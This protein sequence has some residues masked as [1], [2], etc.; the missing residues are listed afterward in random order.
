MADSNLQQTVSRAFKGI[1][2]F[3]EDATFIV[4]GKN[5]YNTAT[6]KVENGDSESYDI[7]GL[8]DTVK[9]AQENR[10]DVTFTF[11]TADLKNASGTVLDLSLISR[12]VLN[13]NQYLISQIN[14]GL[15]YTTTLTLVTGATK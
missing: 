13:N 12:V 5:T 6:G 8:R 10:Y 3:R 7:R 1:D 2:R 15:G 14:E 4:R 11:A 9:N